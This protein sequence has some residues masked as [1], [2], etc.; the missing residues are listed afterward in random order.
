MKR[1]K[2]L[3]KTGQAALIAGFG[4]CNLLLKGCTKGQDFDL[5][6]KEGAILDGMGKEKRAEDIG[7]KGELI[8]Y[9]GKI[10]VSRGKS[11]IDAQGLTVTPGFIDAHDHS[12][13]GLIV[14]PKA[15]SHIHQGITTLV[16]GNCGSSPFPVPDALYEKRRQE[17]KNIYDIELSWRD[18]EGFFS[19]IE[20]RG[21]ALNYSTFLGH[22]AL[23]GAVVGFNDETPGEEGI[24]KMQ[25]LIK[26]NIQSGA[27]GLSSGLEYAPGSYAETSEL[28]SLCKAAGECGGLYATHMRDEGD[29]LLESLDEAITIAR[30]AGVLLQISHLKCAYPRNW[31]KLDKALEKI[32]QAKNQG[33]DVFCDRY[34]YTAG[35]T[36]LSSFNFPLWAHQGTTDDF[37]KRLKDP[38]LE[39]RFREHLK[40]REEKLGSWDKVLISGVVTE[41]NRPFEGKSILECMKLT[42]K[43]A[44]QFMRDLLIEERDQVGMVLFMMNEENLKRILSHPLVGVGCDSS[45]MAPYGKLSGG[46]PH[47][48]GYG[49]F[50]RV[51]GKYIRE[52]RIALLPDMIKK[53]TS[54]PAK[55]FGFKKRGCL[56]KGYYAD[57]VLFD[58]KT[59]KDMATYDDPHRYPE[60]IEFVIVNGE[61][62][63]NRGEHTG[64]LPGKV[65]KK[66]I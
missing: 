35:A 2:F 23:R 60:G 43:D 44:F 50:P 33:V 9:I 1:R 7:I 37:I 27:L 45:V 32:E 62:V 58:K 17:L 38:S 15:E 53:L 18:I 12:D 10:P 49:S 54:L 42:G 14:N 48:R 5:V 41:K 31:G 3:K 25:S 56:E 20:K 63:I 26:Q 55:R 40:A 51:L 52:E 61:V 28:I 11:V 47:P 29:Y 22:G 64:R 4:G 46:K 16:S 13:V 24:R 65:L 66:E 30:E 8:E 57:I 21:T 36:G 59:V 34:P 39:P 6:I 19:E